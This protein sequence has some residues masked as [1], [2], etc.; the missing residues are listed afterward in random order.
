MK[1]KGILQ[2]KKVAVPW[3]RETDVKTDNDGYQI[4]PIAKNATSTLKI[5]WK[6]I[7]RI[8]IYKRD[9]L[10]TDLICLNVATDTESHEINE[11]MDG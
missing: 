2:S 6:E 7:Q 5:Q 3:W 1:I 4:I 9:L 10:T 11:E 8:S